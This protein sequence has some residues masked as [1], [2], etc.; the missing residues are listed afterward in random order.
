[1]IKT[2]KFITEALGWLRIAASPTIIGLFLGALVYNSNPS[3]LT[4]LIGILI[5]ISGIIVGVVWATRI[6]KKQGTM[7]FL[8][9]TMAS[10]DLDKK[11]NEK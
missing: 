7:W 1:M 2:L 4:L 10:P 6:W 3:V 5:A 8:S 11:E 9:R